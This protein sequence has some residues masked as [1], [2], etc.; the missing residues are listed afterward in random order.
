MA[1]DGRRAARN[2]T[3][4]HRRHR[5]IRQQSTQWHIAR[6]TR[7]HTAQHI[8]ADTHNSTGNRHTHERRHAVGTRSRRAAAEETQLGRVAAAAKR[9]RRRC[10]TRGRCKDTGNFKVNVGGGGRG[11]H[12][13]SLPVP[14]SYMTCMPGARTGRPSEET[15]SVR[16]TC[17]DRRERWFTDSGERDEITE[18]RQ[19]IE[20]RGECEGRRDGRRETGE[21]NE[22]KSCQDRKQRAVCQ[23][24]ATVEEEQARSVVKTARKKNE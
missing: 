14:I 18:T 22:D 13:P 23:R 4:L 2:R 20:M 24:V 11:T 5:D 7:A 19:K 17:G 10:G 9:R 16:W 6:H 8:T 12:R 1:T 15:T 3:A 21:E